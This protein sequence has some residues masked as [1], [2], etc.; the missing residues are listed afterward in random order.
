[1]PI[2][3]VGVLLVAVYESPW[4]LVFFAALGIGAITPSVLKAREYASAVEVSD[5]GL[6]AKTFWRRKVNLKWTEIASVAIVPASDRRR[7]LVLKSRD[8]SKRL[9]LSDRLSDLDALETAIRE[10]ATEATWKQGSALWLRLRYG[11]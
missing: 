6:G 7:R 11:V 8:R 3:Y 2:V 1:V 9:V 4:I 10:H 5:A